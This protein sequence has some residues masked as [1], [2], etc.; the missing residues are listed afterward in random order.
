M[1]LPT[2]CSLLS[3]VL[4]CSAGII[5]KFFHFEITAHAY[6]DGCGDEKQESVF[7]Q[8]GE[9][10]DFGEPFRGL[11]YTWE[12][13]VEKWIEQ[14]HEYGLCEIWIL[15]GPMFQ[16]EPIISIPGVCTTAFSRCGYKSLHLSGKR[17]GEF[18]Q[19][20]QYGLRAWEQYKALLYR[21]SRS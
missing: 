13:H 17:L 8:Q 9:C 3:L 18:G 11:A 15:G 12:S 6:Q 2:I 14:P 1:D 16:G 7:M 19:M 20:F 10:K 4:A 21:A 5:P